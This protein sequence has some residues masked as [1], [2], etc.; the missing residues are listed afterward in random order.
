MNVGFI[1]SFLVLL[2]VFH[3]STMYE[4]GILKQQLYSEKLL[5]FQWGWGDPRR[6]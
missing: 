4:F 3:I 1:Y 6:S 2:P 5:T